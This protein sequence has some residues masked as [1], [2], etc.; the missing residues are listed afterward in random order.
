MTITIHDVEQGTPEWDAAR[1][2]IIT[3]SVIGKLITPSTLKPAANETSRGITL[4]LV[5]ERITGNTDPTY[6]SADMERGHIDE[7][8][9]R[10]LYREH[11]APVQEVGFI[12]REDR[13]VRVGYSPDGLV[14][15]DG[16]IEIKSRAQKAQLATILNDEIPAENVAQL[17]TG[18]YVTGRKWIDYVSFCSGMPLYVKRMTPDPE[19]QTAI[20]RTAAAL[21]ATAILLL[22]AYKKAV[23][24]LPET[25]RVP[26]IEEMRF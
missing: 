9:A 11:H 6:L 26:E 1:R 22:D 8:V 23:V 20:F 12:T 10:E 4:Q 3:A 2:G 19:W 14:G 24:G 16:L 21:E 5:A 13:G 7:P 15:D 25:I 18:L 17:Q